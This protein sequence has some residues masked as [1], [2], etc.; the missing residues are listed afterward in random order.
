MTPE[1]FLAWR[2]LANRKDNSK[3]LSEAKTAKLLGCA[4]SSVQRWS[5]D[6]EAPQAFDYG[7]GQSVNGTLDAVVA[8]QRD[9]ELP[10]RLRPTALRRLVCIAEYV[11]HEMALIVVQL[12]VV[13]INALSHLTLPRRLRRGKR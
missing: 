2:H 6:E 1:D 3:L 13:V 5:K 8:S 10:T 4:Q 12:V 7:T 9:V 11:I